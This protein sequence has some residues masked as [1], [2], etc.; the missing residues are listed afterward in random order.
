M[1]AATGFADK[2]VLFIDSYH[3][4]YDWSDGVVD[5][6]RQVLK[7][8]ETELR[9]FRMD[10]KRNQSEAFKRG[11]ALQAKALIESFQPDVVIASDDNASKY[12]IQ[13][14]YRDADLPVVFCGVNWDA[15]VYGYPYANATGMVEVELIEPLVAQLRQLAKGDKM[16][17][18]AI[19]GTTSEKDYAHHAKILGKPYDKT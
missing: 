17:F 1:F 9:I 16:G 4:G 2:K 15:S 11:A 13:P 10:T 6:V 18:L 14:Y 7:D 8:T 12:L 5:G 3:V 19:G